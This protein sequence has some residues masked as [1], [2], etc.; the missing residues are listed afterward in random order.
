MKFP[1]ITKI[2]QHY[3]LIYSKI[4]SGSLYGLVIPTT[5]LYP[6]WNL[7]ANIQFNWNGCQYYVIDDIIQ[8]YID[9]INVIESIQPI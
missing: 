8:I 9:D 4:P 5:I 1:F 7:S 6:F 2:N 3:A